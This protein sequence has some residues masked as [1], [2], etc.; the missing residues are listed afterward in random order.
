MFFFLSVPLKLAMDSGKALNDDGAS[1]KVS[2]LQGSMLS[3]GPFSVVLVSNHH[4]V[5]SIGLDY[6]V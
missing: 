3:A 6:T 5:L 1:S 4:P 2:W